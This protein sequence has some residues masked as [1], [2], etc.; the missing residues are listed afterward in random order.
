MV[1]YV[2]RN[3]MMQKI[4]L[5]CLKLPIDLNTELLQVLQ[6]ILSIQVME[7]Q[8]FFWKSESTDF[9]NRL[10]SFTW[11]THVTLYTHLLKL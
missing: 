11:G 8:H 2:G 1:L 7:L 5:I 4:K 6:M 3:W 10:C 9:I